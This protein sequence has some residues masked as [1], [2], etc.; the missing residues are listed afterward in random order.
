M[1]LCWGAAGWRACRLWQP[2]AWAGRARIA[3][4]FALR[5]EMKAAAMG[6]GYKP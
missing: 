5:E 1:Q 4:S 2:P 6:A 3:Q